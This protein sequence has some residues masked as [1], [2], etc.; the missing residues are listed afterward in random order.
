MPNYLKIYQSL[1]HT[2]ANLNRQKF[3]GA[4]YEKHHI[5][6]RSL[7]GSNNSDNIVL[8]TAREHYI[9][10]L[11]LYHHYKTIGGTD[12]RKMSFALVSMSSTN[13]NLKRNRLSSRQYALI[14]EA[15]RN[16]RLGHKVIN[17]QKYRQP[18][19]DTHKQSIRDARLNAVPRS[20]QTRIKMSNS[21]VKRGSNFKGNHTI[22]TC[23]Y[24]MKEGQ[25]NA[26]LRWHFSKCKEVTYA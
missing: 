24:C 22:V 15:A 23:P 5:I 25:T 21:A 16:S 14:K 17:T 18:K 6:P 7:G 19:S 8:L 10:H 3:A 20:I 4:Y 12:F 1:C 2:R 13:K 26:M 11:L 9:A